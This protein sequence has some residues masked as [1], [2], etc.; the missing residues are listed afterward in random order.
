MSDVLRDLLPREIAAA[1]ASHPGE[2]L[3]AVDLRTLL[4]E[5]AALKA[6]VRAATVELREARQGAEE[7]SRSLRQELDRSADREGALRRAADAER[8]G[9][10]RALIDVADRLEAA[11]RGAR[12]PVPRRRFFARRPDPALGAL[13]EGLEL[14]LRGLHDR[15]AALGLHR[16]AAAEGRFDPETMEALRVER[17]NDLPEGTVLEE[18]T[19]GWCDDRGPVRVAQ[20]VVSRRQPAA[21]DEHE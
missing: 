1:D 8:R 10:A 12:V 13:C 4:G 3:P 5:M 21:G 6:E 20:V 16:I 11:L 7:S 14:T 15:L 9:A 19:A 2:A 18:I 17:R